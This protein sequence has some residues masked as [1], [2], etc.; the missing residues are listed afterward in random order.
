MSHLAK[1]SK[2]PSWLGQDEDHPGWT[3]GNA[4]KAAPFADSQ[5]WSWMQADESGSA[6]GPSSSQTPYLVPLDERVSFT[7][8]LTAGDGVNDADL[9]GQ[10]ANYRMAGIPDGIGAYDNNDG[11]FTILMNHEI[12]AAFGA[13][14]DHGGTGAFV[15]RFIVDKDT[16][17]VVS[18]DDLIEEVFV[19]DTTTDSYR[20]GVGAELQFDRLCSGD[21]P[22]QSAFFFESKRGDLGYEGRI[23]LN[24]EESFG[25][26]LLSNGRAFAHVATGAEAGNSYE[27]AW[28]GNQAWENVVANP[29]T[30]ARTVVIGIDD[31][32]D[33]E[34]YVYVGDKKATGNA[35]ERAGLT[36][37]RLFGIR[38]DGVANESR[39]DG[40][41]AGAD[42]ADGNVDRGRASFSLVAL[43]DDGD[44]SEWDAAQL[45]A[46]TEAKG[47]TDFLR[48]EDGA[49]DPTNPNVFYFV[50]T[51]AFNSQEA[52]GTPGAAGQSRLYKLT[53]RDAADPLRGGTIE[54]LLDG[55]E[56]P[57]MMDNITV[58]SRG[59]VLIQEDS[60]NEQ[61]SAKIWLYDP[62]ADTRRAGSDK[63]DTGL[64]LLAEHDPARFGDRDA[65]PATPDRPATAPYNTNEESSGILDVSDIFGVKGEDVYLLDVQ[66][67]YRTGDETYEGG[68]LLAMTLDASHSYNEGWLFG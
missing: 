9:P 36:D 38:V 45:N 46:D 68:Q 42:A 61:H 28:M 22:D 33:G 10:D 7:S 5:E 53:F 15:S 60:G 21:L 29:G 47:V 3:R 43:G 52:Y 44:V 67:H 41:D 59:Q 64:T 27:L 4:G 34:L 14:R 62:Q 55:S 17:Q 65:D 51:D 54:M 50:T 24:G 40:I 13:V 66:A 39:T 32:S 25:A 6:T 49:W 20:P 12:P 11:T 30:G 58:N 8:I 57:Q 1:K 18:G 56:L 16:L 48:P 26:S 19:Y 31:S 2:K 63:G 35:V 23:Y 37:G